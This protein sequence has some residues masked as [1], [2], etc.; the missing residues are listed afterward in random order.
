M[1][2]LRT[3]STRQY[4]NPK[5]SVTW[6]LHRPPHPN[7]HLCRTDTREWPSHYASRS[8]GMAHVA[9]RD[10]SSAVRRRLCAQHAPQHVVGTQDDRASR[11][12]STALVSQSSA[13]APHDVVQQVRVLVVHSMY[14][15][16]W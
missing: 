5:A 12:R 7:E 3:G 16:L 15:V 2:Y 8:K 1:I 11:S 4:L 14:S 9:R 6:N 10:V 13:Q